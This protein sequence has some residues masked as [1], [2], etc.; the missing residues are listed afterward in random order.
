MSGELLLRNRQRDRPL[1][2]PLLRQLLLYLLRDLAGVRSF[3]LG[4]HLVDPNTIMRLNQSFLRHAGSTDVITFNY[5]ERRK[6][7]K[8]HGDIFVCVKE[9]VVQSRRFRTSWQAELARYLV[10]GL[11]HLQGYD[12]LKTQDRREMKKIENRLVAALAHQF[13][14]RR[15][16]RPPRSP[17]PAP[18]STPRPSDS[19]R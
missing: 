3:E 13:S 14:L 1:N 6:P 5:L 17:Q 8:V 19:P 4:V 10:H 15:L 16:G 12:D 9:G 7:S 2:L 18:R 11:L